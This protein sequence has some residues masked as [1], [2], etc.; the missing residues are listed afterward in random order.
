MSST[1]VV[2]QDAELFVLCQERLD[3]CI[4]DAP[5]NQ[6]G[7]AED[8]QRGMGISRAFE[9]VGQ[10]GAVLGRNVRLDGTALASRRQRLRLGGLGNPLLPPRSDKVTDIPR[11][12]TEC[13]K[14]L[15]RAHLLLA[16][17]LRLDLLGPGRADH[18]LVLGPTHAVFRRVLVQGE[19]L[20]RVQIIN[21]GTDETTCAQP[22]RHARQHDEMLLLVPLVE[23]LF[24]LLPVLE[25]DAHRHQDVLLARVFD[26]GQVFKGGG[27]ALADQVVAAAVDG[28]VGANVAFPLRLDR[29]APQG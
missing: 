18:G 6:D 19:I 20:P 1:G 11:R 26:L 16:N 4:P 24:A 14:Q 22:A 25:I 12:G 8:Y 10:L 15:V 13:I 27:F 3:E 17:H 9:S 2:T 28:D 7:V 21:L 5:V 29:R 23:L